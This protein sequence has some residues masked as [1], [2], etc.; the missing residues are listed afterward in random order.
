MK[1]L[2]LGSAGQIGHHLCS[3]LLMQGEEVIQF[4]IS[5]DPR[6]DLRIHN[7][8]LLDNKIREADFIHFLAYDIGGSKYLATHQHSFD[9][10]NNN[11]LIMSNV[12]SLLKKYNKPFIFA[13]SQMADMQHSTYGLLKSI[14]EKFTRDLEG[15][16]CRFWNVYGWESDIE[17]SHVIT[18]FIRMAKEDKHIKMRTTGNEVRQFLYATDCAKCLLQITKDPKYRGTSY[19]I[20]S[21]KW[22][23][24]IDIATI[25]ASLFQD[26]EIT[27]GKKKDLVQLNSMNAPREDVLKFWKPETK[28]IEGIKL[29]KELM[30]PDVTTTTT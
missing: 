30:Y 4:D 20:T 8:Q 10:I 24:I 16:I 23:P 17:K 29:V 2:V 28:L 3:Y 21:F 22:D 1:H 26:V 6:Q 14:G 11:I 13:S 27:P 19:D 9:F 15:T 25:A 18:D 12:F 7:N 5:N